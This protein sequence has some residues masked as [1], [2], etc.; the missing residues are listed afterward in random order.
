MRDA[1]P[2]AAAGSFPLDQIA[3]VNLAG[4]EKFF[5]VHENSD[6]LSNLPNLA[7]DSCSIV[8]GQSLT[9][10]GTMSG[11]TFTPARVLPDK[12]GF[13]GTAASDIANA[14]FTF[15]AQGL[16]GTLL[17]SPVTVQ[18]LQAGEFNTDFQNDSGGIA[19]GTKLH[20]AGLVLWDSAA[21]TTEILAL[22][23]VQPDQ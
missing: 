8:P 22:R 12:Q 3:S 2:G 1:L 6:L 14:E 23:V 11:S 13:S 7:F 19:A 17:P 9:I 15:N 18:V 20:V 10:G 21:Q 4:T 16:A 5:F